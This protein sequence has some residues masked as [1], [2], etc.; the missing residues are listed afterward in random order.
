MSLPCP[1]GR[2]KGISSYTNHRLFHDPHLVSVLTRCKYFSIF[3]FF[4][5]TLWSA[6]MTKFISQKVFLVNNIMSGY[7]GRIRWSIYISK[8][9]YYYYWSFSYQLYLMVFIGVRV[10]QI[11]C[12]LARSLY[13]F[14]FHSF[15]FTLLSVRIAKFIWWQVLLAL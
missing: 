13:F 11:F 7:L 2:S 3:S 12:S 8:S 14:A 10:K 15:I 1:W 9:H 5:F 6:G 4:I